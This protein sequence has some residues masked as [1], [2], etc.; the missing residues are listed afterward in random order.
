MREA[1]SNS[2]TKCGLCS[3][4]A[5]IPDRFSD[6]DAR[7]LDGVFNVCGECG[8]ECSGTDA[9]GVENRWYWTGA[10]EVGIARARMEAMEADAEWAESMRW[11]Y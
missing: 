11:D 3:G 5:Y 7:E 8:A 6:R 4:E 1:R 9:W 10:R 2:A